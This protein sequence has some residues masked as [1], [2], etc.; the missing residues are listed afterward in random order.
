MSK[1]L[2]INPKKR[3]KARSAAQKAATRRMLA[4]NRRGGAKRRRRNPVTVRSAS[5]VPA[6]R[7]RM[8]RRTNPVATIPARRR[9]RNPISLGGLNV[10]SIM[11]AV[12]DAAI[13]AG[14]AVGVDLLMGKIGPM[15]PA[16]LQRTPGTVGA[17]D[18]V[19]L[20]VTI[21]AGKL[22]A[23]PTRGL[24]VKMAQGALTVQ[25]HGILSQF[26][27]AGLTLG[28]MGY[29]SPGVVVSGTNRIGPTRRASNVAAYAAP[30]VTPMLNGGGR[31]GAYAQPGTSPLLSR[32][33]QARGRENISAFR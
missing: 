29:Y 28:G 1:M 4:A 26:M 6:V 25:A 12:K 9:R 13:G 24:S 3:R 30:G 27:P 20:L 18:A 7:R 5:T 31:V 16:S 33:T 8:A 23:K 17:G 14:G 19:K 22:L 2:L 15:L 21:L 32:F 11:S 10:K